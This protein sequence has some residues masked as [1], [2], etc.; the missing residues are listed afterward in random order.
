[1]FQKFAACFSSYQ[2]RGRRM[3]TVVQDATIDLNVN[4]TVHD[5]DGNEVREVYLGDWVQ[6]RSFLHSASGK[7]NCLQIS[8]AERFQ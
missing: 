1:M 6:L 8:M 3:K 2:Q 4:L 5:K 7:N